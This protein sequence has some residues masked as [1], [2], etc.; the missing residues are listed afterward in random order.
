M[1]GSGKPPELHPSVMGFKCK[2]CGRP[3]QAN[4]MYIVV[5]QSGRS[6]IKQ[7]DVCL[8]CLGLLLLTSPTVVKALVDIL[9]IETKKV[10]SPG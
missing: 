1:Q 6:A 10:E 2:R 9:L 7:D 5:K 8:E 3:L 4:A